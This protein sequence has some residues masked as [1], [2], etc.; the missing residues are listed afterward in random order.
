MTRITT[1]C[2]VCGEIELDPDE[3]VIVRRSRTRSHYAFAHCDGIMIRPAKR[4]V[5][6]ILEMAGVESVDVRRY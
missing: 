4:R 5:V 3:I 2:D 1:W 6:A